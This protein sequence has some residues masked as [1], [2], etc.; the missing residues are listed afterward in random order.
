[1]FAASLRRPSSIHSGLAPRSAPAQRHNPAAW[2]ASGSSSLSGIDGPSLARYIDGVGITQAPLPGH[3]A[4]AIGIAAFVVVYADGLWSLAQHFEVMAHEGMHAI[5][6]SIL[7]FPVRS[8]EL[9]RT[10][11]GKTTYRVPTVGGRGVL[12]GFVGYLGPSIFGLAAAGLISL[13]FIVAVLWLAVAFLVVLLLALLRSFR[14]AR[15]F[16]CVTVPVTMA[17]FFVLIHY[18]S[19]S[20]QVVLAYGMTWVLLLSGFRTAGQHWTGASDAANLK[21]RTHLPRWLWAV[22]WVAGTLGAIY[23]GWRLLV[24]RS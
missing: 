24:M 6:G 21:N 13:G 1:M 11:D 16:G 3:D 20:L 5:T 7:G 8:I 17:L 9:K 19:V 23:L 18:A 4:A 15:T 22:L 10:G 2:R 14:Y 12:T